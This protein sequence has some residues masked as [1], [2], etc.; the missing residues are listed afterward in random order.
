MW[1]QFTN[2][3]SAGNHVTSRLTVTHDGD[4]IEIDVASTGR[5]NV[6]EGLAE[7]MIESDQFAVEAADAP[8]ESS[9]YSDS[10]DSYSSDDSDSDSDRDSDSY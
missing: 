10:D 5:A 7:R 6:P 1:V 2:T 3:D 4:P 9:S 8:E